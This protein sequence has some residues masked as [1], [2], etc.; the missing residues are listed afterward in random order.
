MGR[1]R[2]L[3]PELTEGIA[4]AV[5]L[6]V[7]FAALVLVIVLGHNP[8]IT[9][10]AMPRALGLSGPALVAVSLGLGVLLAVAVIRLTRELSAHVPRVRELGLALRPRIARSRTASLLTT[11]IVVGIA[12]ELLFRGL[13]LPLVGVWLSSLLFGVV[14]QTR[15]HARVVWV[16]SAA[17]MGLAFA[18]IFWLTGS[19][20]GAML[21]HV[22]INAENARYLRD[23]M[24]D[25]KPRKNLGGL[26]SGR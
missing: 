18:G 4:Y 24:T 1:R 17:A 6:V 12:E 20:L 10:P 15:G 7:I 3:I 9:T 13:L 5:A 19:I 16:A 2:K 21:A 23:Q 11:A 26:L 14:H 25:G 8:L 22:V